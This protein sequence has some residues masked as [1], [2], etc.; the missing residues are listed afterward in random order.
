MQFGRNMQ[1]IIKEVQAYMK[2]KQKE[3]KK[4]TFIDAFIIILLVCC[5][6]SLLYAIAIH[7]FF[8]ISRGEGLS[9]EPTIRNNAFIFSTKTYFGIDKGEFVLAEPLALNKESILKR[10]VA[11]EGDHVVIQDG[12]MYINDKDVTEGE[13]VYY[14]QPVEL[15][16]PDNE[17][18]LMGDNIS[19]SYDSRNFGCITEDEI[20]DN[21][22]SVKVFL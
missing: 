4:K 18:F 22:E 20:I 8:H 7:T 9:N 2:E 21:L 3:N 6:L 11:T 5:A 13:D 12:R 17:Y 1:A 10:V 19:N 16:V 15:I 14:G